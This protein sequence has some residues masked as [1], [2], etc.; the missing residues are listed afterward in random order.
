MARKTK[1]TELEQLAATW[2]G[3]LDAQ[4]NGKVKRGRKL[5][6]SGAKARFY[7]EVCEARLGKILKAETCPRSCSATKLMG[8]P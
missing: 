1:M 6:G 7:H 8:P 3:K 2:T 5:A 4:D